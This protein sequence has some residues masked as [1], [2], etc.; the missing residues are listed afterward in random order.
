MFVFC[1]FTWKV[2]AHSFPPK[3]SPFEYQSLTSPTLGL[4]GGSEKFRLALSGRTVALVS[5]YCIYN[6]FNG[7]LW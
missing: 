6:S 5:L 1:F 3:I 7:F 4:K 2:Q